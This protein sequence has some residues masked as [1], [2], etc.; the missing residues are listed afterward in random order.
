LEEKV[1]EAKKRSLRKPRVRKAPTMREQAETARA[2]SE[3]SEKPKR[4]RKTFSKAGSTLK[5]T[6]LTHNPVVKFLARIGRFI[7]KILRWLVPK[8]FVNS[9]R[10]VRLVTWPS[11]IETWRLTM[12]VFVFAII[13]G[14]MVAGVDKVLD[15]I[16]KKVVLK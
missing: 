13:F 3:E 5:K 11:R 8:Y 12:A 4:V 16:F 2:K 7:L 10:E 6:R 15:I 14:A 1:A 9:W